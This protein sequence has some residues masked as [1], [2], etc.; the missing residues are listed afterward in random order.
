MTVRDD[1]AG[2][3]RSGESRNPFLGSGKKVDPGSGPG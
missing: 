3:R 1:G 2:N